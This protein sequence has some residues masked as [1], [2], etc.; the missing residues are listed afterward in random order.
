[1]LS[2]IEEES[3]DDA[4]RILSLLCT[5]RRPLTVRELIDGIAVELGDHPRFNADSRLMNEEDIRRICPGFI[6]LDLQPA[7]TKPRCASPITRCRNIWNRP[8]SKL[9]WQQGSASD[10]RRLI[11]KLP[12]SVW[13]T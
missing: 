5:A 10:A 2:N 11:P 3:A 8:A 4:R 6:E 7:K 1:M 12:P 13:Y 9:G